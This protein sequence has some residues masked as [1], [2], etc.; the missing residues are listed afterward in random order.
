MKNNEIKSA[1]KN[2]FLDLYLKIPIQE[3]RVNK[4]C[5]KAHIGRSTFYHYYKNPEAILKEIEMEII[6]DMLHIYLEYNYID[7]FC[8]DDNIPAPNFY[9]MYKYVLRHKKIFRCFFKLENYSY[10][11][12]ESK[13]NIADKLKKTFSKYMNNDKIIHYSCEFCAEYILNACLMLIH[14]SDIISPKTLAIQTK[15]TI[16]DMIKNQE[17]YFLKEEIK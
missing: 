13:K 15:K 7:L 9:E 10:F 14:Y 11:I 12:Q 6:D 2:T 16:C 1:I 5:A 3:I 8:L 4:I 17:I